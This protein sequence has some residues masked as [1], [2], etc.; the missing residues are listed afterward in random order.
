LPV[1]SSVSRFEYLVSRLSVRGAKI[2][3]LALFVL[4]LIAL[5]GCGE[6]KRTTATRV[7]PP[8]PISTESNTGATKPAERAGK[9]K[10]PTEPPESLPEPTDDYAKAKPVYIEVGVASW[11][12][13][14]YH[15]RRGS[16]GEVFDMNALTAAHRTLP[17]NSV[18]R[19]TNVETGSSAIVRITDRGPFI[20]GRMLDLSLAAA[21]AVD[22]WRAGL[23]TVRLEVLHTPSPILTG[24][25][26]CVQIGAFTDVDEAAKLKKKLMQKYAQ[27]Q[28]L[29]FTGPTGDWVRIRVRG[30]DKTQS[31]EIAHDTR[32]SEGAVFLVRLD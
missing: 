23:A 20:E 18:A 24:G 28:V 3:G 13:P 2:V 7:P 31:E 1:P 11:Y 25:R 15:N 8:P 4:A 22:V 21:K 19:V 5:T 27:A 26:W 14:P 16:N 10:P 12:G 6:K 9:H 30:D 17:L 32:T 29:Q